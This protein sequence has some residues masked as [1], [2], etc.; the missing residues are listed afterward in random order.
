MYPDYHRRQKSRCI[1]VE[2]NNFKENWTQLRQMR[3][4]QIAARRLW[5]Q[6]DKT[7]VLYIIIYL[8]LL[9]YNPL[10]WRCD[11]QTL[12]V[13][14]MWNFW[15]GRQNRNHTVP[16]IMCT[17]GNKGILNILS[18]HQLI[19]WSQNQHDHN[20]PSPRELFFSFSPTS[21][22]AGIGLQ[23]WPSPQLHWTN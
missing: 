17:Q 9:M 18:L 8:F 5:E 13:K 22:T 11:S 12:S 16:A 10:A 6:S 20:P 2:L 3:S 4:R 14:Y 15:L 19:L 21:S 23:L 1:L 7:T